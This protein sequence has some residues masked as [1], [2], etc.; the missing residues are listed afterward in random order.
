[1]FLPAERQPELDA[2]AAAALRWLEAASLPMIDLQEPRH[3]RAALEVL[4]VCPNGKAA[5]PSTFRRSGWCSTT[6]LE[7]AVEPG[8]LDANPLD[9]VKWKPRRPNNVV[10]RRVVV[11]PRQARELLVAVTYIGRTRGPMLAGMFACMRTAPDGR[12]FYTRGGGTFLSGSYPKVWREARRL[13]LTPEQFDS[14][15]AGRPTT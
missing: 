3:A 11:N 15:L 10:D 4:A 8:E 2:Q 6:P 13:A 12:L 7:Y 5:A 1:M 14:P 9:R